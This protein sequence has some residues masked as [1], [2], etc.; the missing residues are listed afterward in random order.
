MPVQAEII[1]VASIVAASCAL[2]GVFLIL[3]RVALMSDALSHAILLGIVVSFFMVRDLDSFLLIIGATLTGI[4]TVTLTE[5]LINSKRM[6]KDAAIGLVFPVF[7]SLAVILITQ[8]A[9][10]AHLDEDAVLYGEL[11]W[12]PFNRLILSG[13]D[14]GPVALWKMMIVLL[15]NI[16]FIAIF[17]KELKISTFDSALSL[18]LGFSPV[19]LHY[20]LMTIVSIT[21]VT[22]FDAV[23]SIL[24]V[25]LMITPPATAYLLTKRLS[26]MLLYSV[27]IAIS[28]AILGYI[29]ASLIN[30]SIAG[31]MATATGVL[32]LIALFL[33]P[34]QGL[35]FKFYDHKRQ[36]IEFSTTMLMVQLLTHEGTQQEKKENTVSNMVEHMEW[37]PLL[38]KQV[39][40]FA[41]HRGYVNRNGDHLILT[42]LGRELARSA[43]VMS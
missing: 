13:I 9:D 2:P 7:F 35:V 29:L 6:N 23:G 38:A 41:V 39:A 11:A 42:P 16:L 36:Q 25:A 43:M 4:L 40:Q 31:C 17:Y 27:G 5:L 30:S 14:L 34:S 24:V 18:S 20:G 21:A 37:S 12:V 8:F 33:S 28:S 1:L 15:L 19:L 22:A 32:F 10:N 26:R 3:R